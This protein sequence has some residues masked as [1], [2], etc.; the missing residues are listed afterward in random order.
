MRQAAKHETGFGLFPLIKHT[1]RTAGFVKVRGVNIGFTD[2]EDMMFN[3]EEVSDFRVEIT[4]GDDRDELDLHVELTQD[5]DTAAAIESI[6][7]SVQRVFGLTPRIIESR[8]G[9][10]RPSLR[11][12]LQA[13]TGQRSAGVRPVAQYR[14]PLPASTPS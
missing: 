12:R 14:L 3:L 11:R 4:G 2:L 10:N 5:G 6:S 7:A 9:R 13:C 1:H 8:T